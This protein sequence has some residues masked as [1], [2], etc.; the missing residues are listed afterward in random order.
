MVAEKSPE[1][2]KDIVETFATSSADDWINVDKVPHFFLGILYGA[3]LCLGGFLSFM[4]TGSISGIRFGTI[5]GG[6]L[7]DL[8]I[9]SM[10]SFKRG[11]SSALALKGE[12]AKEH[13]EH[14]LDSFGEELGV[15][16][17]FE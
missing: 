6:A 13:S 3:F 16:Y 5:L 17:G 2:V 11:Q 10:R 1:Q 7:L 12:A 9:S 15:M 14:H 4:L 8:S